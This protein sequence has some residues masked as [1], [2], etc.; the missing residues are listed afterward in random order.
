MKEC[1]SQN[2]DG[3][4][5]ARCIYYTS[6]SD[7]EYG[8]S[9][10]CTNRRANRKF[11]KYI[12]RVESIR[13]KFASQHSIVHSE[14]SCPFHKDIDYKAIEERDRKVKIR[15]EKNKSKWKDHYGD[16]WATDGIS[17]TKDIKFHS[18]G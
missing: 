14:L 12:S 4:D 10:W 16:T 18:R 11:K 5:Y 3:C 6:T 2:K 9:P 13:R 8:G 17:G 1:R 15:E 7:G